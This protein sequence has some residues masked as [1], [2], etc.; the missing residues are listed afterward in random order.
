[1]INRAAGDSRR[2]DP[3][4]VAVRRVRWRLALLTAALFCALLLVLS[5][6][7][8]G[9][10]RVALMQSLQDALQHQTLPFAQAIDDGR[11]V[12][13]LREAVPA[14]RREALHL[15]APGNTH[16]ALIVVDP[17]L[18]RAL[19]AG[20]SLRMPALDPAAAQRALHAR[21]TSPYST[22]QV[23]PNG[24][25]LIYT[26]A[27]RPAGR[28]IGGVLQLG[29]SEQQ[30]LD[31][32]AT[33][34]TILVAV[35]VPGLIAAAVISGLLAQHAVRPIRQALRRQRDF[36]ADAAHEL[37][38][39]L[40]V[41]RTASELGLTSQSEAE[42]TAALEQDLAQTVHLTRLVEGLSLLART[43]SE[44]VPLDQTPIDLSCVAT[45][46]VNSMAFLAE[47]QGVQV[48]VSAPP[49]MV[50]RGDVGRLRQ[51]LLILLDNALKHTPSGGTVSV[52]VAREGRHVIVR[53]Q[54][55]GPGIASDDLSHVFDRFYRADHARSGGGT[56]LGLAIA[57]WIAET[58]RGRI[59]AENVTSGG[60][61]FVVTFPA[62]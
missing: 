61:L 25:Y 20:S 31:S 22:Q 5:G 2:T 43:D 58:H 28:S 40:A 37:R 1:V 7:I 35:S 29:L 56:G 10:A 59:R 47:Y 32:L 54:D 8:Y 36:V 57:R 19:G 46:A 4:A 24:P 30:Y 16:L 34:R 38:T 18:A 14:L 3:D 41:M 11:A 12:P 15:P 62:E 42:R 17:R 44:A 50:V 21:L 52:G 27:L 60:A 48:A 26:V 55:T 49:T 6:I 13:Y 51:L 23:D 9:V 39:P 53:V 33:L 45:E